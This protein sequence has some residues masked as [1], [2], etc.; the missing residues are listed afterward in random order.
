MKNFSFRKY[1]V[2]VRSSMIVEW[3]THIMFGVMLTLLFYICLLL[4]NHLAKIS[5]A[6]LPNEEMMVKLGI[7]GFMK[8]LILFSIISLAVGYF[9]AQTVY[10]FSTPNTKYAS[11]MQPASK[12][13]LFAVMVTR[14]F[15]ISVIEAFC[16]FIIADLLQWA[17]TGDF[18]VDYYGSIDWEYVHRT[19]AL[20]K[21]TDILFEK[22]IATAV[23]GVLFCSSWFSL[24]ATLFRRHPFIFG[25]LLL[26]VMTQIVS[27]A[28]FVV[29]GFS[30]DLRQWTDNGMYE[31]DLA[32]LLP[33]LDKFTNI[34]L[35]ML[36][37]ATILFWATSYIRIKK[38]ASAKYE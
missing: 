11:I 18:P 4:Y 34:V 28:L 26:W 32:L 24:C 3:K 15:L 12:L 31:I 37:F 17:T 2:L 7:Y 6:E 8:I 30:T 36:S 33:K 5:V 21:G 9:S 29:V 1:I 22:V 10:Y 23:I 13:E 16:A 25:M 19:R 38:V 27:V 35:A 14:S 20:P